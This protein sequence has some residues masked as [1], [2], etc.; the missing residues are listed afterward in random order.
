MGRA[1]VAAVALRPQLWSTAVVQLL[2]LAPTGWWRHRPFLPLPDADYLRF[3]LQTQYGDPDHEPE[4]DD[5][6]RWLEWSKRFAKAV[7]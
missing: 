7:G 4:P 6:V 5:V 3:R 2:R 1:A